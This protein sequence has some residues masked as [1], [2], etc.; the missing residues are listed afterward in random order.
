MPPFIDLFV[1]GALN[2][3]VRFG[4]DDCLST[5]IIQFAKQPIRVKRFV[6]Q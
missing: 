1:V 4:R 3:P 6:S 5:S 2:F